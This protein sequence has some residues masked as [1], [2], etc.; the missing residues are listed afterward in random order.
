VP[1][2]GP[3]VREK[4][5]GLPAMRTCYPS[6]VRGP[7]E[8]DGEAVGVPPFGLTKL[9]A[10]GVCRGGHDLVLFVPHPGS[11]DPTPRQRIFTTSLPSQPSTSSSTLLLP[12]AS[13]PSMRRMSHC[14]HGLLLQ[15]AIAT[16][17]FPIDVPSTTCIARLPS[18]SEPHSTAR[19]SCVAV[20]FPCPTT[21]V[22]ENLTI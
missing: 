4:K 14:C 16:T 13:S 6:H 15:S 20:L 2:S 12:P 10:V 17:L 3:S 11:P 1:P 22:T 9:E 21:P 7:H 8:L 19:P 5:G 18:P